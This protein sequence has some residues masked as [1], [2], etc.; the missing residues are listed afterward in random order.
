VLNAQIQLGAQWPHLEQLLLME[1][2]QHVELELQH[3]QQMLQT[4]LLA[5]HQLDILIHLVHA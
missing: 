3:A 4:Q 1:Q 2:Q 5:W